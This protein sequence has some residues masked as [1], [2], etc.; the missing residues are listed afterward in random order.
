M[1]NRLNTKFIVLLSSVLIILCAGVAF[2]AWVAISGAAEEQAKIGR[3]AEQAGDF[4]EAVSRYGR[5]ISK[6]PM[7]LEYYD[8]YER[9]L[10]QIVPATQTEA[11]ER[12]G[13]QYLQLLSR[14]IGISSGE[15][16][17]MAAADRCLSRTRA[18]DLARESKRP[19]EFGSGTVHSDGR[20]FSQ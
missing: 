9:A 1:N 11:R 5:S 13:Q 17:F 20:Q 2:I 4:K 8:D 7:N 15:S 10:L 19:L 3:A 6:D 14:R 16:R 18:G 12:Y